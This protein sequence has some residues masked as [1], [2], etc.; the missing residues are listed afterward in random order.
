LPK[1]VSEIT[2]KEILNSF[3][4]G[5]SINDI[6][7]EFNYSS[8]TIVRQIKK[9]I[10]LE[11]F[12]KIKE[13]NA[14]NNNKS[15][16]ISSLGSKNFLKNNYDKPIC[17]EQTDNIL[18]SSFLEIVPLTEGVE[19]DIQKDLSSKQLKDANLPEVVYLLVDKKNEISPKLLSDYPQ[20]SSLPEDDLNRLTIEIFADQRDGKRVCSKNEK[21][22]KIPNSDIF[23][24]AS[25]F[26]KKRGVSRI[27]FDKILLSL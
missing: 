15:H 8:Q 16:S 26:L 4:K 24:V 23:I 6:A 7:H 14:I 25:K 5:K 10:G 21:L 19:F 20:W 22:I 11:E 18:E 27:I 3:K 1:K 2:K 17:S 12:L 13:K 9:I